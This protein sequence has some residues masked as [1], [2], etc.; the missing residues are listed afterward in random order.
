MWAHREIRRPCYSQR[1]NLR[2]ATRSIA[3]AFGEKCPP[4]ARILRSV[5][6]PGSAEFSAVP[7][8]RASAD[9]TGSSAPLQHRACFKDQTPPETTPA[10]AP[11]GA[12]PARCDRCTRPLAMTPVD[13]PYPV[14]QVGHALLLDPIPLPSEQFHQAHDPLVEQ[15]LQLIAGGRTR[16]LKDQT[17]CKAR[18]RSDGGTMASA[19]QRRRRRFKLQPFGTG[20]FDPNTSLFVAW[21]HPACRA[22]LAQSWTQM[23][24]VALAC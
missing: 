12:A 19:G 16:L 15:T 7:P 4:R 20:P 5:H 17:R 14:G 11:G 8:L 18:G 10:A 1:L 6:R 22:P 9:R 13:D 21:R 3:G 24:S 2:T 23:A